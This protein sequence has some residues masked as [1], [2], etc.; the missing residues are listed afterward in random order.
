MPAAVASTVSISADV[1]I[2]LRDVREA[3][4]GDDEVFNEL[5]CGINKGK[6][7]KARAMGPW[8]ERSSAHLHT[9][10]PGSPTIVIRS[11]TSMYLEYCHLVPIF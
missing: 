3:K 10:K 6:G 2:H 11:A 8:S 5:E 1:H 4:R 7:R 9:G